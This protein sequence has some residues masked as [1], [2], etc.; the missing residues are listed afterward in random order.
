MRRK[1]EQ[2]R[3]ALPENRASAGLA[4]DAEPT[5]IASKKL[6]SLPAVPAMPEN[7]LLTPREAEAVIE[8]RI[9][10]FGPGSLPRVVV[11]EIRGGRWRVRWDSLEQ[12]VAPMT[13]AEWQVWLERHVGSLD[14]GDLG[15]TES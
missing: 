10:R 8:E 6:S 7:R 11:T 9:E 5:R 3:D 15:T 12:T 13:L 14:A 4:T 2:L 1:P